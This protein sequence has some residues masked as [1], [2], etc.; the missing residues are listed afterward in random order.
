MQ[1]KFVPISCYNILIHKTDSTNGIFFF[2]SLKPT[3]YL[4]ILRE[5]GQKE[6]KCPVSTMWHITTTKK[7]PWKY[8][9]YKIKRKKILF[10][11]LITE[12]LW[13]EKTSNVKEQSKSFSLPHAVTALGFGTTCQCTHNAGKKDT[14]FFMCVSL[15]KSGHGFGALSTTL[16]CACIRMTLWSN[17]SLM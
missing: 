3:L 12:K 2:T 5:K 14:L 16:T 10:N 17:V 8:E 15:S 4:S 13:L 6:R 9:L 11:F 1:L 7:L